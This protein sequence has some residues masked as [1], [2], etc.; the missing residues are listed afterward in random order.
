MSDWGMIV[1]A[2]WFKVDHSSFPYCL[3]NADGSRDTPQTHKYLGTVY[4]L[5]CDTILLP[6][7]ESSTIREALS[8]RNH[9]LKIKNVNGVQSV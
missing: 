9:E 7:S 4:L 5:Y 1:T 8:G 6:D 2:L 3:Q